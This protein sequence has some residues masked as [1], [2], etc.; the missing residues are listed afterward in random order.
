MSVRLVEQLR[1]EVGRREI[2]EP[3]AALAVLEE[4][5][6]S[7]FLQGPRALDLSGA[8]PVVLVLGVNGAGKTT[9]I[10]KLASG[11]RGVGWRVVVGAADTYRAAAIEQLEI[12]A[13]RAGAEVVRHQAGSD[14]AAVAFDAVQAA[15]ARG[16]VALIDTAGRLHTRHNLMEELGKVVRVVGRAAEGA[17]QE[18]L[19]VLDATLGQNSLQ[20]A[21]VFNQV[22]ALSGVVMAKMDGTAKGGVVLSVESEL[23]VPV[24]MIGLGEG[25]SDL[26]SFEPGYFCQEL[27]AGLR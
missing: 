1:R 22:A 2:R 23:R 3:A 6:R 12:W 18:T 21:R 20:Q 27:F 15:A 24:K 10:G 13:E 8:P 9:T 14:P 25:V 7:S 5:F 16:A 17:P 26:A 4:L 11:L 19:L